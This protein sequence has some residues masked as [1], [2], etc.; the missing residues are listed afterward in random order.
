MN[1]LAGLAAG[2]YGCLDSTNS[3]ARFLSTVAVAVDGAGNIYAADT[4]NNLIRKITP[5]GA[6]TTLAGLAGVGGTNDGTGTNALFR[7]PTG[8]ALDNATNLYVADS[9]NHTIREVT[10]AGIVTTF[11]G[12]PGTSGYADGTNTAARFTN[13]AGVAVD[14]AT[15]VYVADFGNS[16]IRKITPAGAVSTLAGLGLAVGADDGT[17]TAARFAMPCGVAVDAFTNVYVADTFNHTIRLITSAGQVSTLAGLAGVPGSADGPGSNALFYA[18]HSLALDGAGNLYVADTFNSVIREITPAGMVITVAGRAGSF[19]VADDKGPFAQFYHPYGLA[20]DGATNLYVADTFN[21]SIRKG[22]PYLLPILTTELQNQAVLGGDT[23]TFTVGAVGA[24][25]LNYQ[26]QK[27]GVNISGATNATLVFASA[28]AV[29]AATYDV[30]VSNAYGSVTNQPVTLAVSVPPNDAFQNA[31]V[32]SGTNFTATGSNIGATSQTGE[33]LHA[34]KTA[35]GRSG[36]R[37]PRRP[38]GA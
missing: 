36:G 18:P 34:G 20:V 2:T 31:I 8:L 29:N 7:H 30:V 12:L 14:A 23:V 25:P 28:V 32:L 13:P 3:A 15:N 35:A 16:V 17:N 9:G 37:G 6:V 22:T 5:A 21:N 27:N 38:T 24:G 1:T 19:G 10:P 4:G 26:W 33:P 11:A